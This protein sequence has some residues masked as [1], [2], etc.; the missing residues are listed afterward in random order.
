ML[1]LAGFAMVRGLARIIRAQYTLPILTLSALASIAQIASCANSSR[2]SDTRPPE[3][4][5]VSRTVSREIR[6]GEIH[7]FHF[8]LASNQYFKLNLDPLDTAV[9]LTIRAPNGETVRQLESYYSGVRAV[10]GLATRPGS[11]SIIVEP[12][13]KSDRSFGYRITIDQMREARG[14]DA[15][16]IAAEKALAEGEQL[17]EAWEEQSSRLAL[18]KFREALSIWREIGD[19]EQA[20]A[21]MRR[22]GEAH[23]SLSELRDA[24]AVYDQALKL[25]PAGQHS[26]LKVDIINLMSLACFYLE[27]IEDARELSEQALDLSRESGYRAGEAMS[28]N[29]MGEYDY[30]KGATTESLKKYEMAHSLCGKLNNRRVLAHTL[31]N[32]G[33]SHTDLG[34][35]LEAFKYYEEALPLW[36]ETGHKRGEAL[37]LTAKG[38]LHSRIGE[39]Q[40]GLNHYRLAVPI[41]ERIGDKLWIAATKNSMAYAYLGLGDLDRSL[42]L[43]DQAQQLWIRNGYDQGVQQSYMQIGEVNTLKGDFDKALANYQKALPHVKEPRPKSYLHKLIG[44]A[45]AARRRYKIALSHYFRALPLYRKSGNRQGEAYLLSEI[46]NVYLALKDRTKALDYYRQALKL[47]REVGDRLGEPHT[48]YLLA[49]LDYDRGDFISAREQIESA[50]EQSESLRSV[51]ISQELRTS[52]STN[53]HQYY[54]LYLDVLMSLNDQCPG[55]GYDALALNVSER[56]RARSL[57]ELLGESKAD[58]LGNTDPA[59]V[60][61]ERELRR[62]LN[63]KAERAIQL[64]GKQNDPD[65]LSTVEELDRLTDEYDDLMALIRER[66]PQFAALTQPQPVSLKSI[67]TSILDDET[68]LL[69]Y[70]SGD[71]HSY[72]WVVSNK[73][74]H[75]YKL[76]SGIEV[77]KLAR[78]VYDLIIARQPLPGETVKGRRDRFAG[79]D[80]EYRQVSASLSAIL[81]EPAAARLSR[82]RLLLVSDGFLQ[83]VPFAALPEPANGAQPLIVNHEIITLPSVTTLAYLKAEKRKPKTHSKEILILA[84]P[85]FE[86]N[87]DRLINGEFKGN[88]ID[89]N[90]SDPTDMA[91]TDLFLPRL[92]ESRDE[93]DAIMSAAAPGSATVVDGFEV[94]RAFVTGPELSRYRI[95]H[96]ATHGILDT[97]RPK[98]SGMALSRYSDRGERIES[99]LSLQDVYNLRLQAELVVLSAC[100]TAVGRDVKGEGLIALTRGF[101]YAGVSRVVASLWKVSDDATTTLMN[102]FYRSMLQDNLSP[103]AALRQAQIKIWRQKRAPYYWAAFV[104]QGDFKGV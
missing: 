26:R 41:L 104:L 45:Y 31:L 47:N 91:E 75:S 28:L 87:D 9:R 24:L 44:G 53:I 100:E 12:L 92:L 81:L 30:W 1:R 66:S 6:R 103:A 15:P 62:A 32:F 96:F 71:K 67:Q 97:Q 3:E 39:K 69:E 40:E 73:S 34:N 43:Y 77:A 21:V 5:V 50:I 16:R 61:Q 94:N 99:F 51:V 98:L 29:N 48:L 57:L 42:S 84:D 59:L 7:A 46:G 88:R 95:I 93:A 74:L 37:T 13:E 83:Y 60:R 56:A 90:S 64:A 11:Y 63:G 55:A 38:Q 89:R 101:M 79:I 49:G 20:V 80:D 68:L 8:R 22:I 23:H 35:T 33:Y 102:E 85:V 10:S 54:Q 36:R 4:L 25:I 78:R 58:I 17:L 2:R 86:K 52:F 72:L 19:Q 70:A 14:G 76:P 18:V 82:K 65:L 27:K